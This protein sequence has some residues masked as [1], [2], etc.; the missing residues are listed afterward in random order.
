MVGAWLQNILRSKLRQK[1]YEIETQL[2]M[3][4]TTNNK[5]TNQIK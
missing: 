5:A 3:S 4:E 1:S 2:D